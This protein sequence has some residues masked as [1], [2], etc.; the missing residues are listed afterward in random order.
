[1]TVRF[2]PV[3]QEE[4]TEFSNPQTC[5][6]LDLSKVKNISKLSSMSVTFPVVSETY[7]FQFVLLYDHFLTVDI[8]TVGT[9]A[10]QQH[11]KCYQM[12]QTI[13]QIM[14]NEITW[15][16]WSRNQQGMLVGNNL[17][18]VILSKLTPT[19]REFTSNAKT[20]SHPLAL[21]TC[22][23]NMDKTSSKMLPSYR[24]VPSTRRESEC[25]YRESE[26][27]ERAM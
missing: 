22:H 4:R 7:H 10:Y 5:C 9:T 17:P 21:Q 3:E 18:A 1:M 14:K 24:H 12:R 26:Q 8:R 2:P 25:L 27:S 23:G 6:I 11:H 15:A 20:M 13:V 16:L 19:E